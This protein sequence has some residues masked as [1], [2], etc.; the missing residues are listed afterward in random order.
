MNLTENFTLAEMLHSDYAVRNGLDNSPEPE[1]LDNIAVLAQ[2]ILQPV[3]DHYGRPVSISSGYRSFTLNLA[4]GGSLNSQHSK[5][6]AADFEIFG[7]DNW[8]VA[9]YIVDNLDFDQ[10]IL[11]FYD[12]DTGGNTGWIH[13]S[14]NLE[15]N[16]GETLRAYKSGHSTVYERYNF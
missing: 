10:L 13:C 9:S 11:E 6:Q 1:H 7:I 2:T 4:I 15:G 12:F 14:Y 5:G 3:R 8:E 16:R